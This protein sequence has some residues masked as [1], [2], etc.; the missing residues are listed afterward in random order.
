MKARDVMVFPVLTVK[1][2]ETVKD[3]AGFFVERG[4]SGAPVVGEDGSL[5]GIISEGDLVYR[6]EIGTQR[7]HPYWFLQYAGAEILAAEYIKARARTVAD[8]MTRKVITATP[9][10]ELNEIAAML[11]DNRIK[12]VPI[13]E[14]G[15]IVGIVSRANLIQ[16]VASASREVESTQSDTAIRAKLLSHL[17]EQHWAH[18]S[19][20]NI[21]VHDGVAE[22]W[23]TVNS[24]AERR[25]I[26]VAAESTP[27][28]RA[29]HDHLVT[30]PRD[31]APKVV[32]RDIT[33]R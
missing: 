26:R 23:G 29:V 13:V 2:H 15:Q 9:E 7:P 33:V 17:N 28:V 22:L 6:S 19:C 11:E 16:A 20:L 31:A 10:T 27:G 14:A 5:L 21:I 3:V 12:R 18:T 4:I 24:D 8:V 30:Q 32:E 25:A 1:P